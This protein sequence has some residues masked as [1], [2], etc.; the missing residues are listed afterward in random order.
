VTI[1]FAMCV[2]A[3]LAL[4]VPATAS[5]GMSG[6]EGRPPLELRLTRLEAELD[7]QAEARDRQADAFDAAIS[8]IEVV[9]GALVGIIA[10]AAVLGALLA[11]R[12]VRELAHRQI[13]A[14]IEMTVEER[15]GMMFEEEA[16][17]LREE[18][19]EK[20]ATLYRRYH[21]LVDEVQ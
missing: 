6:L 2:V 14:Q 12:W 7:A 15:G 16:A 3:A 5:A 1:Q 21:R 17:E 18:Y 19:D 8:R 4:G 13:A 9:D 20:F 11:I 10:L